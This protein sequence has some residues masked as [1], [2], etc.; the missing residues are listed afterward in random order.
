MSKNFRRSAVA[1]VLAA[2]MVLSSQGVLT[3]FAVGENETSTAVDVLALEPS[4]ITEDTDVANEPGDISGTETSDVTE[5]C[6]KTEGC[7]LSK[8]HEG[9]CQ[10][11]P[12]DPPVENENGEGETQPCD[13][14]EGCTLP[15][16]HEGECVTEPVTPPEEENGEDETYPCEKTEGCTLPNGHE[17]ECVVEENT[18]DTE[19]TQEPSEED[20]AAAVQAV[21]DRI[22]SLPTTDDLANYTPTIELK[23]ED[24][25]YQEAYQA[26]LDAYYSQVQEQVKAA[27][28]A[29]DALTEE[30]KV[31]FDATVLA[32][33]ESLE[34]LFAM[35]EQVNML[36]ENTEPK[37]IT[38]PG[39][40]TTLQEAVNN[41][42][43]GDTIQLTGDI[44]ESVKINVAEN[45]FSLTIDLNNHK[46][47]GTNIGQI[48]ITFLNSN[49]ESVSL[50]IKNGTIANYT[51]LSDYGGAALFI[52]N[53]NL[54][55]E[56]CIFENNGANSGSAI[57]SQ[58][59]SCAVTISIDNS[60][61]INNTARTGG[62][63]IGISRNAPSEGVPLVE[64]TITDS[65]FTG[66]HA[67][68]Y[69]AGAIYTSRTNAVITN[70]VFT[71]NSTENDG[72]AIGG[73]ICLDNAER[74][75]ING[76]SFS[77]NS[78][79]YGG[80]I[81]ITTNSN[82]FLNN[83][84]MTGNTAFL[85]GGAI[86]NDTNAT[87]TG[88]ALTQ[89]TAGNWGGAIYSSRG[90]ES[91]DTP[92]LSVN[93]TEISNNSSASGGAIYSFQNTASINTSLT[94]NTASSSGGALYANKATVEFTG[95]ITDNTAS[96]NGG[97]VFATQSNVTVNGNLMDN[98]A[99]KDGG[100]IHGRWSNVNVTGTITHN[101]AANG[102]GIY[103]FTNV[104]GEQYDG[105]LDITG[106]DVYNNIASNSAADIFLGENNHMQ[107]NAVGENW[108][109]EACGDTITG[110]FDDSEGNRWEA[111]NDPKHTE[112]LTGFESGVDGELSLIAAHA[113]T[114][115]GIDPDPNPD[116]DP[117][118]TP[119]R[120]SRPNRDDD[121]D[122]EPL[123]DAPVKDKPEKVE[124]ETVVPEETETPTE[125]PDKY[126]P[127]TGDTTTVFAA[128]A[129]AAVSLGGVVLLGRKKK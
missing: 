119:D 95:D 87:I 107:L 20:I 118:P 8:D 72:V 63:A 73:A 19:D 94:N 114:S 47:D 1:L 17:G 116:P 15:N 16:G 93:N 68:G 24:E 41:A 112:E 90:P 129:L 106:A 79:P 91:V 44:S 57:N 35:R 122:W 117:D 69:T 56:N 120:P 101:E 61:F 48:A 50:T 23:P 40:Y 26:A 108:T 34:N 88:G 100:A 67:G 109:L 5:P 13:K 76:G 54:I 89:N 102:G 71:N 58:T 21:V 65:Q 36:P 30:Q 98:S 62:G 27:R 77:G 103:F 55:V 66:N 78:A 127:E 104:S 46:M 59:N 32:K 83:V 84:S 25:G 33:L 45:N 7:T 31:V 43:S 113:Y 51:N 111:H 74:F 125:Q 14:T 12:V 10:I 53:V 28:A 86:Y 18:E 37:T 9:E 52:R 75:Q 99:S 49:Y 85:G 110:W 92:K 3:A 115:S 60:K 80:A 29:Y 96:S 42:N 123:P 97:A 82:G 39:D 105:S 124:V 126:N 11:T 121:D 6:D 4:Q 70:S 128:M 2:T 38:V 22:N 81:G 64:L